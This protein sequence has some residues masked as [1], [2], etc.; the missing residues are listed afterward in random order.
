MAATKKVAE[1]NTTVVAALH[2]HPLLPSPGAEA[3]PILHPHIVGLLVRALRTS[4]GRH[5]R[6]RL[7]LPLCLHGHHCSYPC[8]HGLHCSPCRSPTSMDSIPGG[9]LLPSIHSADAPSVNAASLSNVPPYPSSAP[10]TSI[11]VS[12]LAPLPARILSTPTRP[13]PLSASFP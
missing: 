6:A 9:A 10:T 13:S 12:P 3:Q 11:D 4:C 1:R 8:C 7:P 5:G 2:T